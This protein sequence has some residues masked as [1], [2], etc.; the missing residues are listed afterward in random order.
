MQL[1]FVYVELDNE[2][3]GKPVADYFGI[4][5]N[6]PT[7]ISSILLSSGMCI[8]ISSDFI[9]YSTIE[10]IGIIYFYVGSCLHRK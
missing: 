8:L 2:D 5:G 1:I 7:V 6:A 9:C 10:S 4:A 3:V